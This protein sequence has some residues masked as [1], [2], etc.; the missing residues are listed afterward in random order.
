M[1]KLNNKQ[2]H[3][4]KLE[5]I[6]NSSESSHGATKGNASNSKMTLKQ[7]FEHITDLVLFKKTFVFFL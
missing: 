2:S 7:R 3:Q 4:K 1:S 6:V 5:E